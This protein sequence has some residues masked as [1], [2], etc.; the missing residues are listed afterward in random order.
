MRTGD[1]IFA[2]IQSQITGKYL[3]ALIEYSYIPD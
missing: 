3:A 1:G 2:I